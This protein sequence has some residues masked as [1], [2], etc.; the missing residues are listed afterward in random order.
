MVGR[1]GSLLP[2][3]LSHC[4][5]IQLEV[6]QNVILT[7]SISVSGRSEIRLFTTKGKS[8]DTWLKEA[9]APRYC[10]PTYAR[11]FPTTVISLTRDTSSF[12]TFW[13]RTN[14][15]YPV[16]SI[17]SVFSIVFWTPGI[18][19]QGIL[20]SLK[21]S[22]LLLRR[23]RNFHVDRFRNKFTISNVLSTQ[24]ISLKSPFNYIPHH[25]NWLYRQL[26]NR[27]KSADSQIRTWWMCSYFL[28]PNNS[29][30]KW[31]S[32]Q[33]PSQSGDVGNLLG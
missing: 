21:D 29:V 27:V 6:D 16:A 33:S 15:L 18:R 26:I 13:A 11:S 7:T 20:L 12:H 30:F 32:D 19:S 24:T 8:I 10:H 9:I 25:F 4:V 28:L 17:F 5:K 31:Q 2:P 1:W 23:A 14:V 22:T 3:Y